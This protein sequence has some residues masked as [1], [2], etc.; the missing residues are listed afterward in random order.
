[1]IGM[2]IVSRM[3]NDH[4]RFP[5]PDFPDHFQP[6][7]QR[8]HQ[9]PVVVVH[10]LVLHSEPLSRFPGFHHTPFGQGSTSCGLVPGIA[11]GHGNKLNPVPHLRI[12]NR[13]ASRYKVTIIGMGTNHHDMKRP[14]LSVCQQGNSPCQKNNKKQIFH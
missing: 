12:Q 14:L 5:V 13:G 9:L 8:R 3:G 7:F 10:H 4:I 1:M 11:I 6:V 2:V